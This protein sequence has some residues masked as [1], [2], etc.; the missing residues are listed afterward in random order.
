LVGHLLPPILGHL[1]SQFFSPPSLFTTF[2][3]I[4]AGVDF[5]NENTV[6]CLPTANG[7]EILPNPDA[8][9]TTPTAVTYG[10]ERRYWGGSGEREQLRH[11]SGGVTQLKRL[12]GLPF[13]SALRESLAGEIG[14][15]LVELD[16]GLTG[17]E[18]TFREQTYVLRPAQILAYLLKS[19][20]SVVTNREP[21]VSRYVVTSSPMW[22]DK[23][24]RIVTTAAKL[25]GKPALA[26]VNN[27]TAAAA[28][29]TMLHSGKLP[30]DNP[31]P[32]L[33]L[34]FGASGLSVAV[35]KLKLGTVQMLS[36]TFDAKL[37]GS[38][39]TRVLVEYLLSK[40]TENYKTDPAS[41]A[42]AMIRFRRA[43]EKLKR[44]LSINPVVAFEVQ[45]LPGDVDVSFLVKREE[46]VA[47]IQDLIDRIAAPIE[48]ALTLASVKA[49]DLQVVEILGG[50]SRIPAVREKVAAIVGREP[51][52]AL[53][54]DEGVAAGA[55]YIGALMS[56]GSFRVP[57]VVHDILAIPVSAKCGENEASLFERF[58]AL[59]ADNSLTIK[60][61]QD[62]EVA[63]FSGDDRIG[64]LK[65]E[66]GSE[67]EIEISVKFRV[68]VSSIV[69]IEA[70]VGGDDNHALSYT[71]EWIG[72]VTDEQ[73]QAMQE[74]ESMME[75]AD[76]AEQLIDETKNSLESAL[77][78]L[79]DILR[80]GPEF[81]T[82][83][84]KEN[85]EKLAAEIQLWHDENEFDRLPVEEYQS[86]LE[87][88]TAVS[89]PIT[90]RKRARVSTLEKTQAITQRIAT[91]EK[92]L[93]EDT[94]HA[95]DPEQEAIRTELKRISEAVAGY[96]ARSPQDDS[97]FDIAALEKEVDEAATRQT[98]LKAKPI[99]VE[100]DWSAKARP[101]VIR[102]KLFGCD[103]ADDWEPDRRHSRR[104]TEN[105]ENE[106]RRRL[107]MEDLNEADYDPWSQFFGI[108]RRQPRYPQ[109]GHVDPGA[110]PRRAA[111]AEAARQA[112]IERQ[113]ELR[114]LENERREKEL[115]ER[116]RRSAAWGQPWGQQ[117][118]QPWGGGWAEEQAEA[119][120]RAEAALRRQKAEEEQRR[121]AEEEQRRRLEAAQRAEAAERARRAQVSDPWGRGLGGRW[122]DSPWG[123][124]WNDAFF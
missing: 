62:V 35:A 89:E 13:S 12:I 6:I 38:E 9:R 45:S 82:P 87:K 98:K 107:S 118:G 20:D 75:A 15:K 26:L 2:M 83:E 111:E 10:D 1:S 93:K 99:H 55:G 114:R 104:S 95:T 113:N 36:V 72:Q 81:F 116:Q 16:D 115:A 29:Y 19:V 42:R 37:G 70:V 97:P 85:A 44:T 34:D 46:F 11:T 28:A 27:T 49:E 106:L 17:V 124:S 3:W 69:E 14:A 7:I 50:G 92:G 102:N 90:A 88:L 94:Q 31:V 101:D 64:T 66:T 61:S 59:P 58:A 48:E 80:E 68:T 57:L 96:T 63:I 77:F 25:T 4:P 121:R 78:G 91:I 109:R 47:Q 5:G 117:W 119:Q 108:P 65:I 52:Q 120:R 122:G 51:T 30:L 43:A 39:F 33:F 41:N 86:R 22:N 76:R 103:A 84:E 8:G 71:A 112:E 18:V 53:N 79:N 21:K 123:S 60:A 73:F 67:E 24:R 56:P 40:V 32:A 74:V 100:E 110:S 23:E 54:V 105:D